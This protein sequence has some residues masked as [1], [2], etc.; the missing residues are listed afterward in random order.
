LEDSHRRHEEEKK[1][2]L[3]TDR[4]S[5][6]MGPTD[7]SFL[8]TWDIDPQWKRIDF[9]TFQSLA[10]RAQERFEAI[11]K[12][13]LVE[14]KAAVSSS[15]FILG[16]SETDMVAL[17]SSFMRQDADKSGFLCPQELR[18]MLMDFGF[19]SGKAAD[20]KVV[21]EVMQ[22]AAA[23]SKGE[24]SFGGFVVLI[25]NLR[26]ASNKMRQEEAYALFERCDVDRSGQMSIQEVAQCLAEMGLAPTCSRGQD[27]IRRLLVTCDADGSGELDKV[28]FGHLL[29][30]VTEK[31]RSISRTAEVAFGYK[32]KFKEAQVREYRDYFWEI[33]KDGNGTLD[34]HE[35][36][37]LMHSMQQNIDGDDLR[38]L[39]TK[40]GTKGHCDFS[41]FL[42]L[43]AN[44]ETMAAAG[45]EDGGKADSER[46][47]EAS[48]EATRT[49]RYHRSRL[50]AKLA[51]QL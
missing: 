25:L 26:E 22:E 50:A 14:L 2:R 12:H 40:I 27:E 4:H 7:S 18:C 15:I 1:T 44:I 35:L 33:D 31:L 36:R 47:P 38:L 45:H 46:R 48:P 19:L 13:H 42:Q 6:Q 28:E 20:D 10:L 29:Q 43:M 34:V 16:S 51:H 37:T 8:K 39:M 3:L 23:Q 32:L 11:Q 24:M 5:L 30:L 21:L 9:A 17:H 41:A 49:S